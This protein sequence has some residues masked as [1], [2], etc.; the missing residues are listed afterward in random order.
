MKKI[1]IIEDDPII[2]NELK[3]LLDNAG[4]DGIILRDFNNSYDEF[5]QVKPDLI[6]LDINIPKINGQMLLQKIRKVSNVPII[7]VTSKNSEYDEVLSMTYGADDYITKPYNPI[8]LLLRINAIFKRLEN[9][10]NITRY[11]NL[12]VI[13]HK[14]IIK[15]D[16]KEIILTKNEMIIFNYLLSRRGTIVSRDELMTELWN[17]EEFLND[18]ALTVNISRLRNRL[19]EVGY[20]DVIE[21]RRGQGY[22]LL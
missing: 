15:K 22:I 5:M 1:L 8:I 4:Y 11:E 21:T 19:K 2:S 6:L 3:E 14:G 13:L 12:E 20:E 18:N 16:L 7:M 17:N 10:N 9:K